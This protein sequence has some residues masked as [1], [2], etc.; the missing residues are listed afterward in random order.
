[1]NWASGSML[2]LGLLSLVALCVLVGIQIPAC[3]DPKSCLSIVLNV[4]FGALAALF[5]LIAVSI[6]TAEY[7]PVLKYNK[8]ESIKDPKE[9]Q[10]LMVEV[11][12]DPNT[13]CII[14]N[15][16]EIDEHL[17]LCPTSR[18]RHRFRRDTLSNG[19]KIEMEY[20][21]KLDWSF[22]MGWVALGFAIAATICVCCVACC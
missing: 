18:H 22:Y 15:Q 7:I 9:A 5:I 6:L 16:G 14:K 10:D 17:D 3:M 20:H 21:F 13:A 8:I 4:L 11:L 19:A 1:M 2:I 12:N